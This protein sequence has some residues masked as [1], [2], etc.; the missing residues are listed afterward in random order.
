MYT[1]GKLKGAA[2]RSRLQ[3]PDLGQERMASNKDQD[4]SDGKRRKMH[5]TTP[6]VKDKDDIQI[7]QVKDKITVLCTRSQPS[8]AL[9]LLCLAQLS[10]LARKKNSENMDVHGE[11]YDLCLT[12]LVKGAGTVT[13]L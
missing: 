12:V 5:N 3:D 10:R 4:I 6:Q 1:D 9:M 2:G 7:Q 11:L 13:T 8:E